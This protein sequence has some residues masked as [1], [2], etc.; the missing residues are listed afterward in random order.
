M[1]LFLGPWDDCLHGLGL[2]PQAFDEVEDPLAIDA[3]PR[4][5]FHRELQSGERVNLGARGG[6]GDA[7]VDGPGFVEG[8][9][10]VG[11]AEVQGAGHGAEVRWLEGPGRGVAG[12]AVHPE[13]D[14]ALVHVELGADS[15]VD[16]PREFAG[17]HLRSDAGLLDDLLE[18]RAGDAHVT[19]GAGGGGL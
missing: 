9:A 15:R 17:G 1:R 11:L 6:R 4:G 14:G 19:V 3:L 2:R 18:R 5:V 10:D 8:G 12:L 7:G 16:A 13:P